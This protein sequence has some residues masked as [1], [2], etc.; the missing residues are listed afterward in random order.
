MSTTLIQRA[1]DARA[2]ETLLEESGGELSHP[3]MS[4]W[5]EEVQKNVAEKADHYVTMKDMLKAKAEQFRVES[6]AFQDAAR[7]IESVLDAMNDRVKAAM[8]IMQTDEIRGNLYRFKLSNSAPKLLVDEY[9]IPDA[10][11]MVVMV[12]NVDREKIKT[13]LQAG[14]EVEGARLEPV[15]ALRV[16]LHRGVTK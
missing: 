1:Q 13:A 16:Y 10:F 14:E 2:M 6:K 9:R 3:C 12:T 8:A 11:K 5:L 15:S 7:Q 4:S